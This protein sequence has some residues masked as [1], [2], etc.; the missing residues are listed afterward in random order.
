M[1]YSKLFSRSRGASSG[2]DAADLDHRRL[3]LVYDR[4]ADPGGRARLLPERNELRRAD[5]GGRRLQ[6]GATLRSAGSS[7]ISPAIAD[8]RATLLR[9]ASFRRAILTMDELGQTASRIDLDEAEGPSIQIDDLHVAVAGGLHH[10]E[11][12]AVRPRCRRACP[13]HWRKRRRKNLAV[14]RH[15]RTLALGK[16]PDY[17]P[18][19]VN[20]SCSCRRAPMSRL[21]LCVR[22]SP[23]RSSADAFEAAVIAKALADVGL[24]HLEP[25]LDRWSDGTIS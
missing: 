2:H 11:R 23:I 12:A 16:R 5:D 9:V 8:W 19:L 6:S 1:Q 13:H 17:A 7:T 22:P 18:A 14:P 24:E 25:Q 4:R 15:R 10:A 3:W 20:P 21:A